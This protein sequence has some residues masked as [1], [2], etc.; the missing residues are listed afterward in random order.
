[1]TGIILVNMQIELTIHRSEII[2]RESIL[3]RWL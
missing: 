1:M 3:A 2:I